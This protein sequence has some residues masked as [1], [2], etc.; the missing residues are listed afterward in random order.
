MILP[1]SAATG[2][3][4][5]VSYRDG[6]FATFGVSIWEAGV[7]LNAVLLSAGL[8][9]V[10][11]GWLSSLVWLVIGATFAGRSWPRFVAAGTVLA[12]ATIALTALFKDIDYL[13]G[14]GAFV[15]GT[16]AEFALMSVALAVMSASAS[17]L[18]KTIQ[19]SSLGERRL[20][21]MLVLLLVLLGFLVELVHPEPIKAGIAGSAFGLLAFFAG[22]AWANT[23]SRQRLTW[24]RWLPFLLLPVALGT[25][26]WYWAGRA[27][28]VE[29]Q[30]GSLATGIQRLLIGA[31]IVIVL[32]ALIATWHRP[33]AWLEL[34]K[35]VPGQVWVVL[36]AMALVTSAVLAHGLG[37]SEADSLQAAAEA[38]TQSTPSWAP[39]LGVAARWVC[40]EA[41]GDEPD[42]RIGDSPA[43]FLPTEPENSL[44]WLPHLGTLRIPSQEVVLVNASRGPAQVCNVT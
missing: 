35:P 19:D 24:R 16:T 4:L 36:A 37:R 33:R 13:R 40:V 31:S 42:D 32:G 38:G 26:A 2:A 41:L 28:S 17:N 3:L 20:T 7:E 15:A 22:I 39:L 6:F 11:L 34:T 8:G 18:V 29:D 25:A 43:L 1:L 14:D 30:Y 27:R 5:L 12:S 9:I 23:K 44:L 21:L 10:A